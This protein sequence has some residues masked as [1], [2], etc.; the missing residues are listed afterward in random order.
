MN[1]FYNQYI[2]QL[3]HQLGGQLYYQFR[4]QLHDQ[5]WDQFYNQ[6]SAQLEHITGFDPETN[7]NFHSWIN[8][9]GL[10][11]ESTL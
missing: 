9:Q 5:L 10:I 1:Q 2:N 8:S 6:L 7:V 4:N 3:Y 11:D